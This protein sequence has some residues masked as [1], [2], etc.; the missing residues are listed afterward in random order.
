MERAKQPSA[1][2][3]RKQYSY[4]ESKLKRLSLFPSDS[5]SK[6]ERFLNEDLDFGGDSLNF[7]RKKQGSRKQGE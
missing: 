7:I 1:P 6:F 3:R 4:V 2:T 5:R